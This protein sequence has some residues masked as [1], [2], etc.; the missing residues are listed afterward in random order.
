MFAHFAR[1]F[2]MLMFSE[3]LRF[4]R[5]VFATFLQFSRE[6]KN[7]KQQKQRKGQAI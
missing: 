6:M 3:V 1:R 2:N 4:V 7:A 5:H